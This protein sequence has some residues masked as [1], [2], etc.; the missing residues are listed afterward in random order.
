MSIAG[1]RA[2]LAAALSAITGVTGH[3][4]RPRVLTAGAAWPLL[5]GLEAADPRVPAFEVTWRVVVILPADETAASRWFDTHHEDVAEGLE[6]FGFVQRI[7]PALV[8]TSA[9]DLEAMQV[10][11]RK[12]A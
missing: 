5:V 3:Q 11:V 2:A 8:A 10:T 4:Y 12:E 1:D 9:G 6:N 7:E